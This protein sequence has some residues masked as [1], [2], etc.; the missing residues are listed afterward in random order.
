[1]RPSGRIL[2]VDDDETFLDN[3]R[4]LLAREGYIVE[5]ATTP[6]E[7]RKRLDENDW[8]VVLLDQKLMGSSGP[9]IG[10]DLVGEV[11]TRAPG[12]K[13]I[14]VTA[15]AS[16]QSIERAFGAGA[17]DFLEKKGSFNALLRAK[18]RNAIEAVYE[19]KVA[20]LAREQADTEIAERWA[21]SRIETDSN[22]KGLLLEELIDLIFRTIDG[23][24]HVN[25]NRRSSDEEIDLMIRNESTDPLWSKESPYILVEAKNWSKPC[26]KNELVLFE[27]KL[28]SRHGRAKLGFF[29]APGGFAKT[30]GSAH[31]TGRRD[32]YFVVPIGPEGLEKLVE[33]RDRNAILKELHDQAVVAAN[34]SHS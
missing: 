16:D 7:A 10:V 25:R 8:D 12:A 6:D 2:I 13:P 11:H 34:G 31:A 19:R 32:E 14:I 29:V 33:S 21:Q 30:F 18:L 22:R 4:I 15:Y 26:G 20:A 17:Y 9:D 28:I 27:N 24:H 5:A 1:M 23:F 3:Y